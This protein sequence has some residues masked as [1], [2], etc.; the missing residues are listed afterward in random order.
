M[1]WK[2]FLRDYASFIVFQFLLVGFIMV[3]YWLDGFR[4]VDTAIYSF[5]ISLVLLASFLLIRYLMRQRYLLKI[6]Q[7]PKTM[8]DVLQKNA[9]TPEAMQAEKYMHELYRLYKHELQSLYAGQKRHDQFINQWVHQMKTPISVIELLLQDERPLDKKNVQEEIDRLRRGLDMVLVNARL[10][11]FEEDMQVEQIALK[12]IVTATVNENKR[13]FITKRVFPEIHIEDDI[14]VASDSKW[15]RFII[16]Q[17]V[18]NAV[19]YTFEVN[20]KIVISTT[21]KDD[22]VQLAI[23][24]EGIGIPA[25]DLSRV[26]KAFFTGENG[27]KTGESTGMGLYL[28]KEICEKLGHDLNITSEVGKGTIVTVTFTN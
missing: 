25:S 24:D 14:I 23:C 19:K 3:L 11:N 22:H 27:R 7:L 10:E 9:K 6:T 5:C 2:L 16:G 20:K 12:M 4:N 1:G 21:K 28:A 13:L 17:F 15:L 26:T 18:T 8:E